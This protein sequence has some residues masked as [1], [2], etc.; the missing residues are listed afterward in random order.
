MAGKRLGGKLSR[1]IYLVLG[2]IYFLIGLYLIVDVLGI[3]G[4]VVYDSDDVYI[5]TSVGIIFIIVSIRFIYLESKKKTGKATFEFPFAYNLVIFAVATAIAIAAVGIITYFII[6]L[7]S[8]SSAVFG[9]PF[10]GGEVG[11]ED[12][13]DNQALV[14]FEFANSAE[15]R[16][17]VESATIENLQQGNCQP[18]IGLNISLLPNERIV[19]QFICT[20]IRKATGEISV[21]Y[22]KAESSF[23]QSSKGRIKIPR[24]SS[25]SSSGGSFG[26]SSSS[27]GSSGG[28][29][30]RI[31][32][33]P[34]IV[35][36]ITIGG[37]I[38]APFTTLDTT[39]LVF[40]ITNENAACR[41]SF[42]DKG[43]DD[44]G[45]AG[46]IGQPT[47]GVFVD[48]DCT[49]DETTFHSCQ[50]QE[51]VAEGTYGA[52]VACGDTAGN[53]NDIDNNADAL[54]T[55]EIVLPPSPRIII[56]ESGSS[57]GGG[58]TISPS[59]PLIIDENGGT[60]SSS[61]GGTISEGST[62]GGDSGGS[63]EGFV[64]AENSSMSDSPISKFLKKIF[65][66]F[67]K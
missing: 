47:P 66:F 52:H 48:R 25:G 19:L 34:P 59:S 24:S 8:T 31:D 26:G 17:V 65:G 58:G 27:S 12:F 9:S 10:I 32:F 28:P 16:I 43:Y 30:G 1:I 3:M 61:G 55:L 6:P 67:R 15:Y 5:K 20:R 35:A 13:G 62:T 18:L 39:P 37:D 44:M 46:S 42:A 56:G 54:F 50:L 57:S 33:D 40:A 41:F 36:I 7:T 60:G 21:G 4:D 2:A 38:S 14:S 63:T 49:G 23:S 45:G 29:G 51:I 64:V 53:K 22:R 11:V